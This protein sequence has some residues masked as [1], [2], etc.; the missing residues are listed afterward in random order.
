MEKEIC[1]KSTH[2]DHEWIKNKGQSVFYCICCGVVCKKNK[3]KKFK[4][5]DNILYIHK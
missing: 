2:G 5:P 3:D 1:K 4:M